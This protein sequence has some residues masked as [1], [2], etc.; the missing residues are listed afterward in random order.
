[1][2]KGINKAILIG[3]LGQDPEVRYTPSGAAICNVSLATTEVWRDKESGDKRERTEWHRLVLFGRTAELA[4]E[5]LRKGSQIYV[6]GRIQN[7]KWQTQ[8][9]EDRTTTE[10]VVADMQFLGSRSNTANTAEY[11]SDKK[12]ASGGAAATVKDAPKESSQSAE[13]D[14]EIPF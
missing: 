11:D 5:Y 8:S 3:N 9:G 7:R 14:D 13:F 12:L 4:Q 10:I 1:M 6:E 2:A